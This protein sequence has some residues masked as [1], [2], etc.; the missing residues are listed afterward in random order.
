MTG[1]GFGVWGLWF[2]VRGSGLGFCWDFGFRVSGLGF[3][4]SGLTVLGCRVEGA[5][6]MV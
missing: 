4:V 6:F 2:G 5:G 1:S 3:M